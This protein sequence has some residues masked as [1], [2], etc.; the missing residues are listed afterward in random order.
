LEKSVKILVQFFGHLTRGGGFLAEEMEVPAGI[1][2]KG[3]VDLFGQKYGEAIAA[4]NMEEKYLVMLNGRSLEKDQQF[5]STVQD[6]D[7]ITIFFPI[8]GG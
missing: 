3:V 8:C 6:G 2:V 5:T 4:K 7:R 1:P